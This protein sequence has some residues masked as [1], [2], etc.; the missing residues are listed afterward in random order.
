MKKTSLWLLLLLVLVS[1]SIPCQS[2]RGEEAFSQERALD[3]L[4]YLAETVG[5]RPLGSPQEMAALTYFA[6]RLAE[7][8]CQVEWQRVTH[9]GAEKGESALNTSSFNVIGRLPGEQQREIV[10]GAH[11]DS[12][13]PEIPGANDDGSGV[14]TMIELARVMSLEPHAATIIFVAFCGEEFGLVGSKSFVAQYSLDNVALMLQLDMT[15]NDSPLMLWIDT[16]KAQTPEWLVAASIEAFHDLGYRNIDY[17][18]FFQSMNNAFGGAGSDHQPFLEKGIPAIA[19]VSDVTFPIHTPNDTLEY[20]E[21][22]GLERSGRL[23]LELLRRFDQEQPDEKTGRYMLLLI[24][25]RPFFIPL[26]WLGIF[27]ALS[28]LIGLTTLFR[29]YRARKLNVDW[30]EE[31]KIK[32]SWPKLL[33]INLVIIVT[34]FCSLWLMQWISGQRTPWYAHPGPYIPFVFLFFILGTW[35]GLQLTRRWKLRR[36]PFFY[37]VR[38]FFYLSILTVLAWLASGPRLALFS[39]AGLLFLSLA[40]LARWGWLKAL[41]WLLAPLWT[42]RMLVL[43]EYYEFIIR[44]S[45]MSFAALKT[46]LLTLIFWGIL[47][48]VFVL[49]TMPFL[50]GFAAA[51]RSARGDLLAIK[52]FRKPLPFAPIVLLIIVGIVYLRTIPAYDGP[53]VQDVVV[54][55]KRDAD[56]KTAIDFTTSGTLRGIRAE[57]SGR[58]EILDSRGSF[59]SLDWPLEMDWLKEE[60]ISQIEDQG[61]ERRVLL[62]SRLEFERPPLQVTLRLRS[63]RPFTVA[64]AN[65]RYRHR[66]N[67]VAITWSTHP[68]LMLLSEMELVLP[69]GAKLAADIRA[70]FLE[71]PVP[72]L[73]R[74]KA[75]HF[76]H[77]AE[78]ERKVEIL[79]EK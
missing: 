73:A 38:A 7:Y 11:I 55:Q 37:F 42:F 77:R 79:P 5:P 31:K 72:I 58:E 47:V 62:N 65:V 75:A 8:G 64:G 35:L 76:I 39:A 4:R 22:A 69:L 56:D 67:R 24:G 1:P 54:T 71:T 2:D 51:Y 45:A 53:W 49:W 19:F 60:I 74:G 6:E 46:Y 48:F 43:S 17:P 68:P 32:K 23:I 59:I 57:I 29:L 9:A 15:S 13:S 20:F 41:L 14:A 34:M 25:G 33:V 36:Y 66:K 26:L 63:D 3:H 70:T 12:A 78:I 10:I 44:A 40:C 16:R 27:N 28:L 61:S 52:R 21:P 30:E 50:L 18:T